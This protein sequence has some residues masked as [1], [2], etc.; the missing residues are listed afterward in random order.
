M[1]IA[2]VEDRIVQTAMKIVIEPIFE[3]GFHECS[4]GY[5]P[6]RSAKQASLAIREDLYNRSW[7]VVEI[8]FKS[9]FDSIP[10]AK[11]LKLIS[12]RISDGSMLKLIKKS[13]KV[14]GIDL[15]VVLIVSAEHNASAQIVGQLWEPA[16]FITRAASGEGN[17]GPR[18]PIIRGAPASHFF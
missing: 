9:Y 15:C 13:L 1:G 2:T 6:K 4:Y 3:A 8:D 5:R 17:N 10:H 7:G 12:L 14:G 18:D 16:P 11:L